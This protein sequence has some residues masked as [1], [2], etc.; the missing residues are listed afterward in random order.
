MKES[1]IVNYSHKRGLSFDAKNQKDYFF[2]IEKEEKEQLNYSKDEE[3]NSFDLNLENDRKLKIEDLKATYI[4]KGNHRQELLKLFIY[5]Y[6][7]EKALSE[8]N[9]FLNSQEEEYYL[10]NP[11]W[12]TKFKDF[13][14]YDKFQKKLESMKLR[15]NY[16]NIDS[17][18]EEI[19]S[20]ISDEIKPNDKPL[21]SELKEIK[22]FNTIITN[23]KNISFIKQG[24]I[25]PSKII[26]MIKN[27]IEK[28]NINF[29]KKKIIFKDD[30]IYYIKN[31]K[32]IIGN[33]QNNAL[34]IPNYV[35]SYNSIE[36]EKEEENN[37][38]SSN[39]NEYITQKLCNIKS[40]YQIMK[41][42]KGEEIG[43]L[44]IK[45]EQKSKTIKYPENNLKN[46][47]CEINKGYKEFNSQNDNTNKNYEEIERQK[48]KTE[49]A[50]L[51][52]NNY[53]RGINYLQTNFQIRDRHESYFIYN[54]EFKNMKSPNESFLP[55]NVFNNNLNNI[56]NDQFIWSNKFNEEL[57][58]LKKENIFLRESN[59]EKEKELINA[60]IE[61]ENMKKIK[62]NF[63][64]FKFKEQELNERIQDFE[65]KQEYLN[66]LEEK[67]FYLEKQNKYLE[68]NI[69][70]LTNQKK[71]IKEEIKS[72]QKQI[73]NQQELI[74]IKNNFM[75]DINKFSQEMQQKVNQISNISNI[76]I[77][78]AEFDQLKN[79]N[80]ILKQ[81]NINIINELNILKST[82]KAK[83]QE[84]EKMNK[85]LK[86]KEI[87]LRTINEKFNMTE[88]KNKEFENNNKLLEKQ[89]GNEGKMLEQEN[90]INANENL[91]NEINKLNKQ[92]GNK[93]KE[94][95]NNK[96]EISKLIQEK[97]ILKKKNSELENEITKMKNQIYKF[98]K[99]E[100]LMKNKEKELDNKNRALIAKRNQINKLIDTNKDKAKQNN[101]LEKNISELQKKKE[102]LLEEIKLYEEQISAQ[103]HIINNK[104]NLI[105][106]IDDL[107]NKLKQKDE[108]IGNKNKEIIELRKDKHLLTL[109]CNNKNKENDGLKNNIKIEMQK[110]KTKANLLKDKEKEISN[111]MKK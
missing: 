47:N 80:Y 36:L 77:N 5:L 62:E 28:S 10:I 60:K 61:I 11:D 39:I 13:Y 27:I 59:N 107:N 92:L 111:K 3:F 18:L 16:N 9:I 23:V 38:I 94:L 91:K 55:S 95:L 50:F 30:F 73:L 33:F 49:N 99:K 22:S 70:L 35:F 46:I 15:Y 98:E 88:K 103:K 24:I 37:L 4:N 85:T 7:Y 53:A 101:K 51:K 86:E 89:K 31:E 2:L 52:T 45:R 110:N 97:N 34:F 44:I 20:S 65:E 78:K 83:E 76:E 54:K 106:K 71:D 74:N 56:N 102:E 105:K 100:F 8:K 109:E 64:Y 63:L 40:G 68:N 93:N 104:D 6:F 84:I 58:K 57:D 82:I 21:I 72:N 81:K 48:Q 17:N 32:I 25:L 90:I 29:Q 66:E 19:I 14:S 87:S 12:L 26:N 67:L 108:I 75:N 1:I 69:Q 41:N 43:S 42:A 96:N 79:E